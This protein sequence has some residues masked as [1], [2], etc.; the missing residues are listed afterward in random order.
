MNDP[1]TAPWTAARIDYVLA[2]HTQQRPAR[3]TEVSLSVSAISPGFVCRTRRERGRVPYV[4]STRRVVAR[5]LVDGLVGRF[6]EELFAPA[7]LIK[8]LPVSRV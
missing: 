7:S 1:W 8:A 6:R 3:G 4:M 2:T 5:E